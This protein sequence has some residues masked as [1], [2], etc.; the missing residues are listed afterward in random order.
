MY[1]GLN[2]KVD[3]DYRYYLCPKQV[4]NFQIKFTWHE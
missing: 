3:A 1:E 2:V 4:I